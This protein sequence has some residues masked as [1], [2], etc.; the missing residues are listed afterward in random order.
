MLLRL[1]FWSTYKRRLLLGELEVLQVLVRSSR[2]PMTTTT[3]VLIRKSSRKLCTT[4]ELASS[5]TRS[6]SNAI[7]ILHTSP[8]RTVL[9]N[10][11][12]LGAASRAAVSTN[13]DLLRMGTVTFVSRSSRSSPG[14]TR[15][16]PLSAARASRSNRSGREHHPVYSTPGVASFDRRQHSRPAVVSITRS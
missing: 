7:N 2:L 8:F 1:R 9:R 11:L 6:N 3:R 13:A 16:S 5:Q 14:R 4:S 15:V 12:H 10:L